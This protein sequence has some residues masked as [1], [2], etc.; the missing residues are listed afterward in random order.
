M[1]A[2]GKAARM[3]RLAENSFRKLFNALGVPVLSHAVGRTL[4]D[5]AQGHQ[6]NV[7]TRVPWTGTG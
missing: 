2:W 5:L 3:N 6:N 1:R 7:V 4:L